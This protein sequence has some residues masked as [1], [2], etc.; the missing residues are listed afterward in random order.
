MQN[1]ELKT[2]AASA[3][4]IEKNPRVPKARIGAILPYFGGKRN[5]ASRIIDFLGPHRVYW[6]PF[7]GS[8][9]V[10]FAKEPVVM[11]TVKIMTRM[12]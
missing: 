2:C 4:S 1:E 10:L 6:E 3:G 5:L 8:M 12:R 7:C 11:E 9:A